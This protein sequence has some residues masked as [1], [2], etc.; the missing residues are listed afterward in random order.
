MQGK[1]TRGNGE[2]EDGEAREREAGVE[3]K[4]SL[5]KFAAAPSASRTGYHPPHTGSEF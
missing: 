5:S 1:Q 3:L 4:R 2:E